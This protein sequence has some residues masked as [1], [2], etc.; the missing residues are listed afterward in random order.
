MNIIFDRVPLP[1]A[2]ISQL[3]GRANSLAELSQQVGPM[4]DAVLA[5]YAAADAPVGT[6]IAWYNG[7]TELMSF[8]VGVDTPLRDPNSYGLANMVLPPVPD[9][10]VARYI[11]PTQ[12]ISEAWRAMRQYFAQQGLRPAWDCR[13]RYHLLNPGGVTDWVIELQQ[14]IC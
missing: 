12:G 1:G 2:T 7:E 11:G 10:I 3:A 13:E 8:G 4:V 5:A 14:P 9:A 6:T